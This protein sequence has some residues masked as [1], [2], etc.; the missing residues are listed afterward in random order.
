MDQLVAARKLIEEL[1]KEEQIEVRRAEIVGRDLAKHVEALGRPP[2]AMVVGAAI[3]IGVF[4]ISLAILKMEGLL[5]ERHS[6]AVARVAAGR[7][8]SSTSR[9]RVIAIGIGTAFV[10]VGF[11]ALRAVS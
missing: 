8:P 2:T 7:A 10:G 6:E 3:A 5:A 9:G 11:L 1:V 4:S